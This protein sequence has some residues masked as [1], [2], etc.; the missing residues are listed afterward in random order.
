MRYMLFYTGLASTPFSVGL[1][2]ITTGEVICEISTNEPT[3]KATRAKRDK[4]MDILKNKYST[5]VA[6]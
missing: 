3:G 6:E 1:K 5:L 4:Y 2:N